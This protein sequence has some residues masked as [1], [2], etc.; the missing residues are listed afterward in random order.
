MNKRFLL[1]PTTLPNPHRVLVL[2]HSNLTSPTPVGKLFVGYGSKMFKL[3]PCTILRDLAF[4]E[5]APK[6]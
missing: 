3:M 4:A 1:T 6:L 5:V 2:P